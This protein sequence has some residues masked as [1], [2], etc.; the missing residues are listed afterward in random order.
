MKP[1]IHLSDIDQRLRQWAF[2]HSA[3]E[4]QYNVLMP[5][6]TLRKAGYHEAFPHLLMTASIKEEPIAEKETLKSAGWCLSP[7]VCYHT[8][9]ALET[10]HLE[11]GVRI[12]AKGHCFRNEEIS[13]LRPGRRQVEFQMRELVLV[14]SAAW[15]Q[16]ELE[17]I[18]EE[19]RGI[20]KEYQLDGAWEA[21][22]DPF[23]L[24]VAKGKAHMQ[25]LLG[26]KLEY[27]LPDGLSIASIN[28]HGDFFGKR[29]SIT[30]ASGD[31]AHSACIAFGLDRWASQAITPIK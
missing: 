1:L 8:Y 28:R 19:L 14:G 10:Q 9:A 5:E 20:A 27:C 13:E 17:G 16:T 21:A 6:A 3:E 11:S 15:I 2:T 12:T 18:Q 25:K 23:F 24:P 31:P 22:S 26:T 29:F 7:A 30:A 4:Q